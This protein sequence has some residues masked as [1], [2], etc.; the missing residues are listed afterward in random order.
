MKH[1]PLLIVALIAFCISP[2]ARA[3]LDSEI[4]AVLRDKLIEKNP[5]G[6]AIVRLDSAG[7][8]GKLIYAH[9]PDLPLMPASN[10]KLLTTSAALDTLG[11]DFHFQTL[12]LQRGEDLIL[13]GDGDPMFGDWEHLHKSNWDIT[14]AFKLWADKLKKANLTRF[15][16][17]LVDDTVFDQE[18]VHPNWPADQLLN[19][20]CAQIAGMNLNTGL[21]DFY[22]HNNGPGKVVGYHTNPPTNYVTVTNTC[23]AGGQNAIVLD[24]AKN[25]NRIALRGSAVGSSTSPV[26]VT[27]HDPA[28]YAAQVL[29]ETLKAEGITINGGFG[30]DKDARAQLIAKDAA[31]TVLAGHESTLVQVMSRANKDSQN[32][33]A[34]SLCKRTG[35][36]AS[37]KSGSW[38]NGTAATAVFLRKAG[39]AEGTFKL[40]DGCGLSR[41]NGVSASAMT[42]ALRYNFTGKNRDVF[43]STLAV[44]G[45]DGTLDDRFKGPAIGLRTR[46]YAKTGFIA[47]VSALSGY[48]KAKDESWYAFSILMN[49]MPRFTNTRAK[50]LQEQIVLAVDHYADRK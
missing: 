48:L 21:I 46:V 12:L 31:V 30:R 8:P 14:S 15:H 22:I 43:L 50:E 24:R 33:Y 1:F 17:V 39:A 4:A 37:G 41:N 45:V 40:D 36:A 26:S 3:D 20:Y 29:A 25:S 7:G 27:V 47:G 18:F 10:M 32:L 34:E 38:E 2:F 6:V 5:V 42:A 11:P 13:L 49:G 35:H 19:R 9:N 16:N 28:L 23:T 44:A